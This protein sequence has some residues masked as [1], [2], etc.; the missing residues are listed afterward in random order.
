VFTPTAAA[1]IALAMANQIPW[2]RKVGAGLAGLVLAVVAFG[3]A[4][5]GLVCKEDG[6]AAAAATLV[7]A[8]AVEAPV[9]LEP[10]AAGE[11]CVM[12]A[13]VHGHCHHPA[14]VVPAQFGA[15]AGAVVGADARLGGGQAV[16]PA[17]ACLAGL[18]R[19]P[20]A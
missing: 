18:K 16:L 9:D 20:R 17:S 2:W 1:P 12:G 14:Q 4:V 7:V 10:D 11:Q 13:C 6:L 8:V 15:D 5:D 3:P 19:P